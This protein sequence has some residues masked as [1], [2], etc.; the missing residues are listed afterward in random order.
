MANTLK[1]SRRECR[2]HDGRAYVVLLE[3]DGRQTYYHGVV[4]G[5]PG[6]TIAAAL[7]KIDAAFRRGKKKGGDEWNYDDVF[8]AIRAAGLDLI[9][10]ATWYEHLAE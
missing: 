5:P 3:N 8:A 1:T 6:L 2:E 10:A 9:D 4:V 7:K